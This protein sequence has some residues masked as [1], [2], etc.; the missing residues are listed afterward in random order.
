[1]AVI[2]YRSTLATDPIRNFRFLAKFIPSDPALN[3]VV[4]F[5]ATVGFTSISGLS[6]TTD[7]IPYREGGYNTTPH[8]IP[9][10]TSFTP[11][12]MQRGVVLGTS[13]NWDW[14][15]TLFATVST[16]Q[17]SL[18]VNQNFRCDIEILV[19]AHPVALQDLTAGNS[20]KDL[21]AMRYRAYNA[22]PTSVAYSDLNAGDNALLVEQMALVHEGL[23]L[24]WAKN[25]NTT[26]DLFI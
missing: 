3:A 9:G 1:M 8:Q 19:L 6:V 13:Q 21:V 22:W 14:M 20:A 2:N 7:A 16:G 26:A 24:I 4:P 18:T 23:D 25:L 15:R 5:S 17:T 12:T 11:I 10:Q